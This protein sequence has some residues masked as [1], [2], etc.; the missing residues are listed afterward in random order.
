MIEPRR[1]KVNAFSAFVELVSRACEKL[2]PGIGRYDRI[3]YGRVVRI[4][5]GVGRATAS[6]KLWSADIEL[7]LPDL[8]PDSSRGII[9]DVPID[10]VE[11]S[12]DGRAL[13]PV[14]SVGLV[15]RLGW[16]YGRRD[17]PF[18]QSFTAEGQVLPY[19][20][21]G[22]LSSVIARALTLLSYPRQTA[23]GPG[24]MGPEYAELMKII[25]TLPGGGPL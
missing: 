5:R 20:D 3:V 18:I 16:M 13:F 19:A 11:I 14:V 9:K 24:P 12:G 22:Q 23:V 6:S 1:P 8:S 25:M 10:P 4:S 21:D 7:L 17:L 2:Y 15:V